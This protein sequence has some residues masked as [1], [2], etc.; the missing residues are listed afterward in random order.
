MK[1]K[2]NH[3]ETEYKYM[4]IASEKLFQYTKVFF[5]KEDYAATL[6][7]SR[8]ENFWSYC[9]KRLNLQNKQLGHYYRKGSLSAVTCLDS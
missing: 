7:Q 4:F 2:K 9:Q 3:L 1:L 6:K 5:L 8:K